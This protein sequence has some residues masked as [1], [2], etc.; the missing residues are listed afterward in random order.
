MS[1]ATKEL[2]TSARY[3]AVLSVIDYQEEVTVD[4]INFY[5][6]PEISLKPEIESLENLG[7]LEED[8]NYYTANDEY[9]EDIEELGELVQ[10]DHNGK[11]EDIEITEDDKDS[12]E[13]ERT[14]LIA[15][16]A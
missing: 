13:K 4:D 2:Y 6:Q 10:I 15:W 9:R 3:L 8:S 5:A 7:I 1:H 16:I 11:W 14:D 12:I